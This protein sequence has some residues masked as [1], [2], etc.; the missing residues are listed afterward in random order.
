MVMD[1]LNVKCAR[2]ECAQM[3]CAPC[4]KNCI[5]PLNQFFYLAVDYK[6]NLVVISDYVEYPE[7]EV[8][9]NDQQITFHDKE[10][11]DFNK[12]DTKLLYNGIHKITW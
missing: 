8:D 9:M 6:G 1:A 4:N 11:T 5:Q 7:V 10:V 3:G 12:P 2:K